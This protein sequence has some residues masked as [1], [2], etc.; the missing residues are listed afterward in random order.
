MLDWDQPRKVSGVEGYES[1]GTWIAKG[2]QGSHWRTNWQIALVYHEIWK[3]WAIKRRKG[4]DRVEV[5]KSI[6]GVHI[7]LQVYESGEVMMSMN[8]TLHMWP[9]DLDEL[10]LA[11]KEAKQY[12]VDAT[13]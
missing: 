13:G 6:R 3:A 11:I 2:R 8:G 7:L 4:I 5:K 1:R 12:F 9:N 10:N